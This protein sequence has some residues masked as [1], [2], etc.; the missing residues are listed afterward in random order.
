MKMIFT[1][2]AKLSLLLTLC[3]ILSF[4]AIAQ[5]ADIAYWHFNAAPYSGAITA[6]TGTGTLY[7]NGTNG[8]SSGWSTTSFGG[9]AG[10][11]IAFVGD[12]NNGKHMV[13]RF[14]MTGKQNARVTFQTRGTGTGYTTGTWAY[15]EDG[16]TWTTI[17][18]VN[19]ASTSTSFSQKQFTTS[20]LDGKANAYLRY[21]L[22]GASSSNGNNRV[23]EFYIA[24]QAGSSPCATPIV[25]AQPANVIVTVPNTATFNTTAINVTAYQ[26]QWRANASGNWANVTVLQGTGGTSS[27]FTTVP[28]VAT[29]DEYQYRVVL[30]NACGGGST[31][32]VLNS[33]TAMLSLNC[34]APV[35][36]LQPLDTTVVSGAPALFV[37]D[38]TG[39]T[40]YQWQ[41]RAN[42]TAT[43]ADVTTAEGTGGT[44]DS[45]T[46]IATTA[47]MSGYQ[48]R[49]VLSNACGG[50]V[51]AGITNTDSATLTICQPPVVT[52]QPLDTTVVLGNVAVFE[53]EANNVS[54]Y[55]WQWRANNTAAW[56]NVTTAEG[57]G[58][59]SDSFTTIATTATMNGFQYRVILTNACGSTTI[60]NLFTDS[61]TLNI[62]MPPVITTQVI[63]TT[64]TL[65]S[66]AVFEVA[67]NNATG[68]QWQWRANNTATWA[69]VTAAEGTGGTTDAFT[70]IATTLTMNGYQ[71]RVVLTNAC[72]ASTVTNLVSDTATLTVVCPPSVSITAQPLNAAINLGANALFTVTATNAAS[73][74]WQV[75]DDLTASWTDIA[76]AAN[77]YSGQHTDS[78]IVNAPALSM[79]STRYR[80]VLSN[81][82]AV[83]TTSTEAMLTIDAGITVMTNPVTALTSNG[84]T[85]VT[86]FTNTGI[87]QYQSQ[88][89][90]Y[91]ADA[92]TWN[93]LVPGGVISNLSPNTQ[94]YFQAYAIFDIGT[95]YGAVSDTFT[96]ANVAGPSSLAALTGGTT[97]Q[98]SINENNNPAY[99]EYAIA[100]G[101][102]WVQANGSLGTTAAWK[103]A[104]D[105]NATTIRE[106]TPR[107]NYCFSVK[108]RNNDGIETALSTEACIQ[109][110]SSVN[111]AV[112]DIAAALS[113]QVILYPN[114][115]TGMVQLKYNFER[116]LDL[117]VTVVDLS[118]KVVL[119]T[120]FND[121]KSGV[122]IIDLSS[123]AQGMYSVRLAS[124][125]H[126]AGKKLL[127]A[128]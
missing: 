117:N 18:G 51:T 61:A 68:Y 5:Y 37:A 39:V 114:P 25:S 19:T 33:N 112:N 99:T 43:W 10:D 105:W 79:D 116:A 86:T 50:T 31:T 124:G 93:P 44:S 11:A 111:V 3:S 97:I 87:G 81:L 49:V 109:T 82:C 122:Q 34:A 22:S 83:T 90:R 128:K 6:N 59:T 48:Y 41:W 23:D 126:V 107:T 28:T 91:S 42:S 58:G 7:L 127:I 1:T 57:I 84:F 40:S 89:I 60:T 55:Q 100:S 101:T 24:A 56:A 63:N 13:F 72:G 45:F 71:Y 70:T 92:I 123:L 64:A 8:S 96:L 35:A 54:A 104:T 20:G 102:N 29:M 21:T 27:S 76:P 75:W 125:G 16:T 73:Y 98:L 62:C 26:W 38:A 95:F 9:S 4:N 46:T 74:Q 47:Q 36:T 115:S 52:T 78:L 94:Y 17:P 85:S 110:D 120:T 106:L 15:S 14:S 69:D 119:A 77:G 30:T 118:G 80:V 12:V 108:A 65:G 103:T 88:G 121:L 2:M 113:G 66:S 32:T 67:G 53:V